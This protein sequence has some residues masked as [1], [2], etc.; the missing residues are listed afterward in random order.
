MPDLPTLGEVGF[1]D[2]QHEIWMGLFAPAGLPQAI[3][4]PL[5]EATETCLADPEVRA[6][7]TRLTF[8]P[9]GGGPAVLAS[10]IVEETPLWAEAARIANVRSE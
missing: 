2:F 8:T 9:G 3:L 7:L 5:S 6:R 10:R 1:P 4:A